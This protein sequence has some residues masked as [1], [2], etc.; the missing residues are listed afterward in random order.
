MAHDDAAM[1]KAAMDLVGL[2][3]G[4]VRPPRRDVSPAGRA[5]LRSVMEALG[6]LRG[7]KT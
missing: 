5:Q 1:V 2:Y 6:A 3:G 7:G 4:R